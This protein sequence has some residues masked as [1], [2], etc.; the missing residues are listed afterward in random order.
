MTKNTMTVG[1]VALLLGLG[2]G[3]LSA[4]FWLGATKTAGGGL[5]GHNAERDSAH[6][7]DGDFERGPHGGRLLS[8]NDYAIEVTIYERGVP[9]Q[10]R[11]YA[12]DAGKAIAPDD[13]DLSIDLHRL[14]GRVDEISFHKEGDFLRGQ[15]VVAEPHSFDV[16]V[17]AQRG[18]ETYSWQ[19]ASYETRV[20][21]SAEAARNAGI[22]VREAGGGRI[23]QTL[24]LRGEIVL[25]ADGVAHIV[26]R[27]SGQVR[28]VRGHL[29][30]NVRAGDVLAVIDSRE[31]AEAKAGDL[32][33]EAKL[34]LM[35]TSLER[36]EKLYE[37]KIAPEEQLLKARQ[38]LAEAEIEHRTAEAK[39]H[40]LGLS[41]AQVRE[42]HEEKDVDY[43]RYEI[44]APFDATVIRKHLALGEVVG[45][46]SDLLVLADLSTVWVDLAVYQKDAARIRLGQPVAVS[47]RGGIP[48][49]KGVID[50]I[51]PVVDE[52]TRTAT[53]RVVLENEGGKLR[54]GVFVT[55]ELVEHEAAV[56]VVVAAE[57]IL[58]I[59]DWSVVFVND[60]DT[61]EARPL[62]LGRSDGRWVEVIQ[63]L[64]PGEKYVAK[65]S[66]V[67]K[68]ELGKAGAAHAH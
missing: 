24:T 18:G 52:V 66:F 48:D 30:D 54:P 63:G 42:L 35:R 57:S 32:A 1:L 60:G 16:E 9:P 17:T 65:N 44:K 37:K 23:A 61:F 55:A 13:I 46:E 14:G 31:L 67:L 56:P 11:V 28:E 59:R 33:A 26:P 53:A 27:V 50:Y 62:E 40:A 41:E 51:T 58:T 29:G 68:A 3:V 12:Y 39:L 43:S 15:S 7:H 10:F 38:E 36:V 5:Q 6:D 2:G 64:S 19:Y 49:A 8:A 4:Y 47:F 20:V 45:A 22:E 21:L 34:S 25:N